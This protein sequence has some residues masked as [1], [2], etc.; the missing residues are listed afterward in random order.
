[1]VEGKTYNYDI[2]GEL[3][4]AGI[5]D[6]VKLVTFP[7][8]KNKLLVRLENLADDEKSAKEVDLRKISYALF[9]QA[10]IKHPRTITDDDITLKEVSITGNMEISEMKNRKI[11]WKTIDDGVIDG[12]VNK[13]QDK[14]DILIQLM[15]M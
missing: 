8:W 13:A 2:S 12:R 3:K 5:K 4:K 14:S 11:Q 7:L 9:K 6:S 15:P 10:N 1:M